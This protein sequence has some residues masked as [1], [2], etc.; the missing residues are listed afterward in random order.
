[1]IEEERK[2]GE[3]GISVVMKIMERNNRTK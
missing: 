1:M 2:K 3:F